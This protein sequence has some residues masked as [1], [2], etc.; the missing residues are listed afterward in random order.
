MKPLECSALN[1]AVSFLCQLPDVKAVHKSVCGK[2]YKGMCSNQC[3]V[4]R[5]VKTP[6]NKHR[7]LICIMIPDACLRFNIHRSF[8]RL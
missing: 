4:L 2:E 5:Q 3:Y 6:Y 7:R 1:P 8:A